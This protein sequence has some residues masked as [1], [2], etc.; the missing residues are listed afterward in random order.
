MIYYFQNEFILYEDFEE[1]EGNLF[2]N[3]SK[4]FPPFD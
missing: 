3:E 4:G 2:G 1:N